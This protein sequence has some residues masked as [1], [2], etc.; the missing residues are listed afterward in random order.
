MQQIAENLEVNLK[1]KQGDWKSKLSGAF[2][3][4]QIFISLAIL[5]VFYIG[6][7]IF[8]GL[9]DVMANYE[10]DGFESCYCEHTHRYFY[11]AWF[12][13]GCIA[14]SLLLTYTYIIVRFPASETN[15]SHANRARSNN[16]GNSIHIMIKVLRFEYYKLYVT[17]Y[18]KGGN[19]KP[20][21]AN[22]QPERG[23][24]DNS[25]GKEKELPC[26]CCIVY[27]KEAKNSVGEYCGCRHTCNTQG[28]GNRVSILK[29]MNYTLLLVIKFLAQFVTLPLLLLQIF[30]THSLLCFSPQLFCTTSSESKAHLAQAAISILFYFSLAL[31]Q[32]ASTMLSWNPWPQKVDKDVQA[33]ASPQTANDDNDVG[34]T[35]SDQLL[36]TS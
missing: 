9:S 3:S 15:N 8:N 33:P 1:E 4:E 22:D 32:L 23:N 35:E 29:N 16:D 20:I 12:S 19:E 2:N 27:V 5:S 7:T 18:D 14:W 11:R 31:S 26:I 30:D 36:P 24:D 34:S 17:G 28:L 10:G 25:D 21:D 13:I 6:Y